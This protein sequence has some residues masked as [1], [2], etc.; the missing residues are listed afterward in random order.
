V[1]SG[2]LYQFG[3][4]PG[5]GSNGAI[6]V[7]A[8]GDF[9]GISFDAVASKVKDAVSLSNYAASGIGVRLRSGCRTPGG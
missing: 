9:G 1:K 6:E 3:Y 8:G 5:N 7:Q 4:S 2:A